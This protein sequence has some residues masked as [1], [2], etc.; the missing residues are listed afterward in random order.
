[1]LPCRLQT[2][3]VQASAAV[4]RPAQLSGLASSLNPG[5]PGLSDVV[6]QL[7]QEAWLLCP[8]F[9]TIVAPATLEAAAVQNQTL[10]RD[11]LSRV[12]LRPPPAGLTGTLP[13]AIAWSWWPGQDPFLPLFIFWQ[14]QYVYSRQVS[15][16]RQT[17]PSTYLSAYSLDQYLIGYQPNAGSIPDFQIDQHAPNTFGLHGVITLSS[18]ATANL[19]DQLRAYCMTTFNYDPASGPPRATDPE[20]TE[21]QQFYEAYA[22]FRGLQVL[23]QG[24][25]GF[26][27][28]LLQR[29]QELQLPLNIPASWVDPAANNLPRSAFW[30]TQFLREQSAS[31]PAGWSGEAIDFNA[32]ASG[33]SAV[34]F[35]PLRAGFLQLQDITLV[36][37]F[38]RFMQ[39]PH[40]N[41]R[42][43]AESL[44]SQVPA[45][46]PDYAVYLPPRIVQPSRVL[47]QWIS[48]ASPDGFAE[49][50]AWNPHPAASP[51][52][53]WLLPNHLDGTLLLYGGDGAPLGSLGQVAQHLRWFTV[54]GEAYPA[55]IDNRTLMLDDLTS[56][57]VNPA[58]QS[59]LR[60][61]AYRDETDATAQNF[62]LFLRV[63][64][65]AQ[66]FI[67]TKAMQEDQALA[68]LI[69]QPLVLA[70]ASIRLQLKGLPYVSLDAGTYMPW[71]GSGAQ[72]TLDGHGF[73]PYNFGNFDDA[74]IT[75]LR[76][77]I[78][79]GAVEY[80]HDGQ[81]LPYFDDGLVGFFLNDDYGTFYT[82]VDVPGA[83]QIRSTAGEGG[84]AAQVTP[85]GDALIVTLLLDPRAAVHL[86][87]GMLPVETLRIPSDQYAAAL[88][89]L[90]VTFLT[91]PALQHGAGLA[92]PVPAEPGYEWSWWHVGLAADQPVAGAQASAG[93]AFPSLPQVIVDGWLKLKRRTS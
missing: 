33:A 75:R 42:A 87:S 5:I 92:L 79:I 65:R 38:G 56:R 34:Y 66:Q 6:Q 9:E 2:E 81:R 91:A 58:L 70:R 26:T 37:A 53:A 24:L 50:T 12:A 46:M 7:V 85:D 52:C 11:Q 67:I 93:A 72:F 17:L 4:A 19:C 41:P 48:A 1:L 89:R 77:P 83:Y 60:A 62:L 20:H 54:P 22:A 40:A 80:R 35:N 57:E 21:L 71:N 51:I 69:G 13:Y 29:A 8:E 44:Q 49:F 64:D 86:T 84:R 59:F 27:S 47:A 14:A 78:D 74:G 10:Q 23:S 36:D 28:G 82:P 16:A 30:R 3:I 76:V 45:P 68:L 55:G 61:F 15:D 31:W 88:S 73:V 25:S 43:V 39:L 18:S 32:F 63:L 90:L